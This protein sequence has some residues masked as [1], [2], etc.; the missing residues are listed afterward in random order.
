MTLVEVLVYG[1]LLVLL[2][3][4]GVRGSLG[5]S[6]ERVAE[7]RLEEILEGGKERL[8]ALALGSKAGFL[9]PPPDWRWTGR[10][11]FW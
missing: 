5:A 4:M 11:G 10:G 2:I 3:S 6:G 7:S 8:E 1:G 9:S